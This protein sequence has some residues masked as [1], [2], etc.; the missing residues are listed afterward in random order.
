LEFFN[1]YHHHH[2]LKE[3]EE[4]EK[5]QKVQMEIQMKLK[6]E[7]SAVTRAR[8]YCIMHVSEEYERLRFISKILNMKMIGAQ[9]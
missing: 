7:I 6:L 4:R 8:G 5:K 1:L 3:E 2:H 9:K